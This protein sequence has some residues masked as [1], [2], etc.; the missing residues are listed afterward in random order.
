MENRNTLRSQTVRCTHCGEYY[1]VT[2]DYCPFCDAGGKESD[3]KNSSLFNT[4]F[5][6]TEE[7]KKK[8]AADRG[9]REIG[10]AH[11]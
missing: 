1:S 10:R 4:L 8:R 2:Y 11:V 5:G 9:R 7:E 3:K 6:A